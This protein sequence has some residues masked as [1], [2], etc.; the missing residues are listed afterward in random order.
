MTIYVDAN[1]RFGKETM[2]GLRIHPEPPKKKQFINPSMTRAWEN[3]KSAYLRDG[4]LDAVLSRASIS[5]DHQKQ[6]IAECTNSDVE[7]GEGQQ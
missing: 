7:T 5:D 4:N 2:E 1:V 6:L 3:A